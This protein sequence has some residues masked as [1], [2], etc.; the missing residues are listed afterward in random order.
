LKEFTKKKNQWEKINAAINEILLT[1]NTNIKTYKLFYG[2]LS[3]INLGEISQFIKNE[4][5]NYF[6]RS[7]TKSKIVKK[8]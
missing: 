2:N 4:I 5:I 8:N 3:D 7:Y 6:A 1:L